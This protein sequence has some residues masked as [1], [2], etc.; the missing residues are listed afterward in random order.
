MVVSWSDRL[1]MEH[2][3]LLQ[4]IGISIVAAAALA[5]VA[6]QVRQP[7]IIGYI[8]GGALLVPH[9]G[10]GV[11]TA[12]KS[13]EIISD[14]GLILLLFI[15]GLEINVP[16]LAQTGRTIIVTGLLQFP[17]CAGLAWWAMAGFGELYTARFDRLYL[18]LALGF[19]STLI[20][21]KLL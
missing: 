17:I 13:I 19:S 12:E 11:I 9:I 18:A 8:V 14:M 3:D 5:F 2:A 6:R 20:V 21:V 16:R 7:L 15:I 4:A 10:L 1:P